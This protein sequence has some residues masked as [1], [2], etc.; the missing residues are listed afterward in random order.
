[1][2]IAVELDDCLVGQTPFLMQSVDILGHDALQQAGPPPV[3]NSQMR[4]VRF[5]GCNGRIRVQTAAPRLAPHL[6][7]VQ[8]VAVVDRRVAGPDATRAAEVRDTRLGADA[9]ARKDHGAGPA[10]L[11]QQRG[12]PFGLN[13]TGGA[14][15]GGNCASHHRPT[16][17]R[18]AS[19]QAGA[20]S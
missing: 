4:R 2:R 19:C 15:I 18:R 6:R 20:T 9:R 17:S 11:R 8:V 14:G 1:M 13:H 3:G 10:G 7:V 12:Q 5:R 16:A